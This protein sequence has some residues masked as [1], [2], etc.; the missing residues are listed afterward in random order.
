MSGGSYDYLYCKDCDELFAYSNI[1]TLEEMESRFLDLGYEDVA[2][3]FRRLI[4]YIKS[5]NNRVEV[6]GGQLNE[7]MHDIEWY[8]G[9][10]IGA[11]TL[12]ERVE[13]YRRADTPQ[14]EET[15][16]RCVYVRGSQWCQGCNGTPKRWDGEKIVDTPQ[17]DCDTCKHYKLACELFSEI[18]KYEPTTQTETQNSNLTIE[19]VMEEIQTQV[20]EF[21][22]THQKF[23]F[24]RKI[25]MDGDSIKIGGWEYKGVKDAERFV[26][27]SEQ[28][29]RSSE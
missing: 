26:K 3:D 23:T 19:K 5:A 8:D 20:I 4:E 12:A 17:T 16:E 2:K 1:R 14:T 29:E 25:E 24:A 7:M 9:G 15:C 10:D 27:G 13:K 11:D 21:P 18:C 22:D 28:T 6:L